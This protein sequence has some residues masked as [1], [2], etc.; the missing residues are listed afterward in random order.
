M[1]GLVVGALVT[2]IVV[3]ESL[4]PFIQARERYLNHLRESGDDYKSL[5]DYRREED[6]H[7][8]EFRSEL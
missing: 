7:K 6:G 5:S 8:S 3:A 4:A 2:F 1:A